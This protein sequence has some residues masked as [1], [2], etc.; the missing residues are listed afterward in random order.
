MPLEMLIMQE[1]KGMSDE[2]LME[3]LHYMQYLKIA[4][5]TA[6]TSNN[7]KEKTIYRSPGL[8]KDQIILKAGFD[9]P[10]DDFE[11]YM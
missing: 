10:L 5:K 3:V 2:E 11:E 8:Y 1:A 9:E 6:V 7:N 4:P